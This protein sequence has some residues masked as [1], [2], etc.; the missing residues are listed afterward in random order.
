MTTLANPALTAFIAQLGEELVFAQVLV[1]RVGAGFE[2]RHREDAAAAVESLR[3]L[4]VDSL[5]EL[6]QATEAGAFRPLKSAPNLRRG[7]RAGVSGEQHLEIALGHLYPG[8]LADW[9]AAR[10]P[11]VRVTHYRE[12]TARQT[13]MYRVTTMLDDAQA[14]AVIRACCDA[15]FCLK[16]R[17]WSVAGMEPGA[18]DSRS[19]IPCLEPCAVFLEFARKAVRLEQEDRIPAP[20][21]AGELG[22]LLESLAAGAAANASRRE[23]DFGDAGNPRRALLLMEKLKALQ[24]PGC[25]E[26]EH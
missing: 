17:L 13:G 14:A 19:V 10:Q 2:L 25:N 16:S 6:A 24:V 12:F 1:R 15:R 11:G 18:P 3:T 21:G 5:R 7:W 8:G 26:G 9:F 22:T 4:A 23:A 20:I